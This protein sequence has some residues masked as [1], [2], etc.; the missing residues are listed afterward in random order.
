MEKEINYEYKTIRYIP[1][2]RGIYTLSYE[3]FGDY[4]L[5]AWEILEQGRQ[6]WKVIASGCNG[7]GEITTVI[8]ER[9]TKGD[10]Q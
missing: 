5:F 1:N 10:A 7:D 2:G 6:G 9:A 3:E 8:M 4:G